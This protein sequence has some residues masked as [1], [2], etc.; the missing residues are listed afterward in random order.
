MKPASKLDNKLEKASEKK[1]DKKTSIKQNLDLSPL[2]EKEKQ[3]HNI[4]TEKGI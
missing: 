3:L 1:S 2:T 4:S